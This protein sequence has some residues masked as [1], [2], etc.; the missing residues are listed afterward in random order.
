MVTIR[1]SGNRTGGRQQRTGVSLVEVIVCIS[2]MAL[3]MGMLIPAVQYS[4]ES[5]R[6][7]SCQNNLHQLGV[8]MANHEAATGRLV[9][10]YGFFDWYEHVLPHLDPTVNPE[11]IFNHTDRKY[12]SASYPFFKCPSDSR[13]QG[14]LQFDQNSYI[15]CDGTIANDF[16]SF[17]ANGFSPPNGGFDGNRIRDITDGLSNT[18]AFSERLA[19]GE[20]RGTAVDVSGLPQEWVRVLVE[21]SDPLLNQTA[22]VDACRTS[23][24]PAV[25]VTWYGERGFKTVLPPNTPSCKWGQYQSATA[26]SL[27]TNGVNV[28][29]ADGSGRFISNEIDSKLWNALGTRA[30]NE[31][32]S[33]PAY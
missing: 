24:R 22:Y 11:L 12:L 31:T 20:Y 4:R 3:L 21:G 13:A 30:G 6:R 19:V 27:H 2:I 32:L 1:V 33:L 29:F 16:G 17:S 9:G 14:K 7:M 23:A 10:A 15:I 18:L 8:A 26:T 5:A 28:L 25:P